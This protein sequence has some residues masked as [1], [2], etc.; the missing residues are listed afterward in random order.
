MTDPPFHL[1]SD[2][3]FKSWVESHTDG[4][5]ES[6]RQTLTSTSL[7]DIKDTWLND[8]LVHFRSEAEMELTEKLAHLKAEAAAF[9]EAERLSTNAAGLEA[10]ASH[11]AEIDAELTRIKAQ[12]ILDLTTKHEE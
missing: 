8:R 7:T 2:P 3:E 6:A 4:L 1:D 10:I 12:I 11:K 9:I 5:W